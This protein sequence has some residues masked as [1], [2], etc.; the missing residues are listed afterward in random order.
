MRKRVELS[1]GLIFLTLQ[2]HNWRNG[3]PGTASS[4]AAIIKESQ[5]KFA[6]PGVAAVAATALVT[7]KS[8]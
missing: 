7:P 3:I 4:Q 8:P 1:P 6:L 2:K 5:M